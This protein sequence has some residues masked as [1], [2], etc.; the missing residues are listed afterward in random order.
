MRI[1][2]VLLLVASSACGD[3]SR[4]VTAQQVADSIAKRGAKSVA[5]ELNR[6]RGLTSWS[7]I[8][9]RVASGELSWLNVAAKLRPFTD[10]GNAEGLD[11]AVA[12]ALPKAPA[13]VLG[14][15]GESFHASR[16][17]SGGQ[18][19][20]V[21]KATVVGFLKRAKAAVGGVGEPALAKSKEKCLSEIDTSLK[22]L[23]AK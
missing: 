6:E 15:L 21:P 17:C 5:N 7:Y 11:N 23:S 18:F 2:C 4:D 13:Q 19:I 12:D 3:S 16:V 8:Q 9:D 1:A 10:A 22:A 14:M 20:E